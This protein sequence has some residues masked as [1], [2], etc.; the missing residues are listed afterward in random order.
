MDT[1]NPKQLSSDISCKTMSYLS[2][3]EA[4]KNSQ[5]IDKVLRTNMYDSYVD[6]FRDKESDL[7]KGSFIDKKNCIYKRPEYNMGDWGDQFMS[8][9]YDRNIF[10]N[11]TKAKTISKQTS[12]FCKDKMLQNDNY[13]LT[14]TNIFTNE[15]SKF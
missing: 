6:G 4:I 11:N 1:Y 9:D 10:N 15:Y 7:I 8:F 12:Q 5:I 2:Q 13:I 14:S 3:D